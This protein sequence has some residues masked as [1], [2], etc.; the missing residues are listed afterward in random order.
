MAKSLSL[1]CFATCISILKS[2]GGIDPSLVQEAISRGHYWALQWEYRGV[3]HSHEDSVVILHETSSVLDMWTAIER[4]YA[5]LSPDDKER[6]EKEASPLGSDVSFRGFDGNNET[7]HFGIAVF[8]LENLG[9]FANFKGKHLNSHS[10]SIDGYRRMLE[11]FEPLRSGLV[12]RDL[13]AENI[14]RLLNARRHPDS[15]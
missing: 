13:S 15:T 11:V 9:Y 3:F 4:A 8:L 1:A 12:D 2:K 14:I 6:V 7:E 5:K 10:P